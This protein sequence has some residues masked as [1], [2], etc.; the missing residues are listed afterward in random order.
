[1]ANPRTVVFLFLVFTFLSL[2][3]YSEIDLAVKNVHGPASSTA[4][5]PIVI[6]EGN[7]ITAIQFELSFDTGVLS[8]GAGSSVLAGEAVTDHSISSN[9]EN[10]LITV[11]VFSGSLD[12]LKEGGGSVVRIHFEVADE[13][14]SGTSSTITVSSIQA[15]DEQGQAVAVTGTDGTFTV[16][17]QDNT[18]EAGENELIFPQIANGSYSG[19][20]Y[21][22]TFIF[23]NRTEATSSGEI[24]LFKSNGSTLPVAL[25][26]GR[27]SSNFNFTVPSG[28]SGK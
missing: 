17:S 14:A 27:T 25:T 12:T 26:D 18:P 22:V 5:V 3:V 21:S 13:A 9:V 7:G 24:S 15:S 10:G 8:V 11:V 28:G 19:G 16:S 23:V 4:V 6:S 20:S 2:P 1:M